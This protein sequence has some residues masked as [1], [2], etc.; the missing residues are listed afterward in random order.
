MPILISYAEAIACHARKLPSVRVTLIRAN[1]DIRPAHFT[2]ISRSADVASVALNRLGTGNWR[3]RI[4][5][6]YLSLP[7]EVSFVN[8]LERVEKALPFDGHRGAC[9]GFR[10]PA[11]RSHRT[12]TERKT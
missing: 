10:K 12:A 6:R 11:E 3:L 5:A 1:D 7:G 9:C 4:A 8:Q 2:T